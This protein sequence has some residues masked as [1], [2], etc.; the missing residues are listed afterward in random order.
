M[1]PHPDRQLRT[2]IHRVPP[3]LHWSDMS[4]WEPHPCSTDWSVGHIWKGTTTSYSKPG[5][6]KFILTNIFVFVIIPQLRDGTDSWNPSLWKMTAL[7]YILPLPM[8]WQ[9]KDAEHHR[10]SSYPFLDLGA[11]CV[12]SNGVGRIWYERKTVFILKPGPRPWFNIKILSYQYRK[13]HCGDKTILRP[14]YLH[15]GISYTGKMA[16]LYWNRAQKG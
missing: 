9:R 13:S 3:H 1:T 11:V 10:S 7:F 12:S 2:Y 16:S 15:K 14:S 5:C 8:A 4:W 6:V